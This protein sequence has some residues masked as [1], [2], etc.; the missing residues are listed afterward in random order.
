[1]SPTKTTQITLP[2]V[3]FRDSLFAAEISVN[4]CE[5]ASKGTKNC[6]QT[7]A[8]FKQRICSGGGNNR[9]SNRVREHENSA[10]P[11]LRVGI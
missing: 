3:Q 4:P 11:Y 10:H 2:E 9:S 6:L 1:M 8:L 5:T 7:S